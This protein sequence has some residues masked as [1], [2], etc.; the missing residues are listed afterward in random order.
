[1]DIISKCVN[2]KWIMMRMKI[3]N[4]IIIHYKIKALCFTL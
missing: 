3:I 1:M 4:P 2:K